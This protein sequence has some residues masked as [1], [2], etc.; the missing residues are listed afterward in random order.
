VPAY[1]CFFLDRNSRI[2]GVEIIEAND[3]AAAIE[4]AL[5]MLKARPHHR[6]VELWQGAFRLYRSDDPSA[7]P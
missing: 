2:R 6:A 4:Q 7:A 5:A 1:R 3:L